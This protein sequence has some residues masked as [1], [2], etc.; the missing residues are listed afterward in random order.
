MTFNLQYSH[1]TETRI[2]VSDWIE[3]ITT[4]EA[5]DIKDAKIKANKKLQHLG[6]WMILDIYPEQ[7]KQ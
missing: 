2:A 4:L 1:P 3:K 7:S 6:T 5:I